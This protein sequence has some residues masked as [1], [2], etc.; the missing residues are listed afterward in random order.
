MK[1]TDIKVRRTFDDGPMRAVVSVTFDNELAV[2][3]IKIISAN[4]RYFLVMPGRKKPD[5]AY[6]DMAHPINSAFRDTLEKAVISEYF[7]FE[8]EEKETAQATRV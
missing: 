3:D 6:R 4:D 1:I 5:G 2:H 7:R 8:K